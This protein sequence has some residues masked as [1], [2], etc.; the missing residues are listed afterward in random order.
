[1]ICEGG[2][3]P[4]HRAG[5]AETR[6]HLGRVR[7]AVVDHEEQCGT[8]KRDGDQFA[9]EVVIGTNRRR[10]KAELPH[11]S[12]EGWRIDCAGAPRSDEPVAGGDSWARSPSR[13][14]VVRCTSIRG[15]VDWL[16]MRFPRLALY[17]Q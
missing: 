16:D 10:T 5:M 3:L 9:H 6:R 8:G 14:P 7:A 11:P 15:L 13:S 17:P 4:H 12:M 1:M 2:R